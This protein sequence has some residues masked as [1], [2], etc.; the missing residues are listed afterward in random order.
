M[1]SKAGL[2]NCRSV[3]KKTAD[4]KV[5]LVDCNLHICALTETWLKEGNDMTRNQLCLEGYS[6]ASVPRVNRAEGGMAL[7]HKLGIKLKAKTVYSDASMECADFILCLLTT[8]INLF[9]IY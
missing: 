8:L 3:V 2:I 6:I 9:I 7:N 1:C 5:E 4:L